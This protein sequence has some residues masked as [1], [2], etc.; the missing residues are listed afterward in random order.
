DKR[1]LVVRLSADPHRDGAPVELLD[2]VLSFDN[3]LGDGGRL[4]RRVF[5]GARATASD[6][7]LAKG[8]NPDVEDTAA[9]VQAAAKTLEAIEA[10][11]NGDAGRAQN[12]L[13]AAAEQAQR[14]A[15]VNGNADLE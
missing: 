7:E 1:D 11:R 14:D 6:E 15:K 5:L 13:N 8:K 12:M 4:E 2:A 10:V 9:S 3:V